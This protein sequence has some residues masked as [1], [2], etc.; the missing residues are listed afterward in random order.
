M[1]VHLWNS[2]FPCLHYLTDVIFILTWGNLFCRGW[3]FL[4]CRGW[5]QPLPAGSRSSRTWDS[6]H[7]STCPRLSAGNGPG[8]SYHTQRTPWAGHWPNPCYRSHQNHLPI[9][10]VRLFSILF[11]EISREIAGGE[12]GSLICP[13]AKSIIFTYLACLLFDCLYSPW[14]GVLMVGAEGPALCFS[15]CKLFVQAQWIQSFFNS[16]AST[17]LAFSAKLL[18]KYPFT[19]FVKATT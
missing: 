7:A 6:L 8:S 13:P 19:T 1:G 9:N 2:S 3:G 12:Q 11:R 4:L 17:A 16:F 18:L 5:I 15:V 10:Q 14:I